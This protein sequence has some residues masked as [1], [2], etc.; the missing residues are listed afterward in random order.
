MKLNKLNQ[1]QDLDEST[2]TSKAYLQYEKFLGELSKKE[3]PDKIVTSI[4]KDIEEINLI[5]DSGNEL[6]KEIKKKQTRIIK[7]IEKE[8]KIVP[9]NYYRN[10][11]LAVGMS[12]FGVPIGVAFGAMLGNMAFLGVGLPIGLAIGVAVGTGMDKKALAEGRQLDLEIQ[13]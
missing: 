7:L 4:N 8:L 10:L 3:L 9:K 6:R 5:S 13:Y 1:R 11:W 2:R 12:A